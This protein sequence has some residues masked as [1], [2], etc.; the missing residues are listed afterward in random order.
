MRTRKEL[1]RTALAALKPVE[2]IDCAEFAEKNFVL[3]TTSAEPGK[4]K[5]SRTPYAEEILKAFTQA[6]IKKVVVMSSSQ[7]GKTSILLAVLARF[8]SVDPCNILLVLPTLELAQDIS[9]DRIES[10]I[11]DCAILTPLFYDENKKS[12]DKNQTMLSKFFKGGRLV[13]VGANSPTGLSSRP[14][15]LLLCDEVDRFAASAGAEGDPIAL[16]ET[17]QL[18]YWNRITGLFST[19]TLENYSRIEQ[20]YK[21]GTQ[22]EWRYECPNC[23]EWHAINYEDIT[24][25]FKYCCP[26]CG[27]EFSEKEMKNARQKYVAQN[28]NSEVRSFWVNAFSSPWVSW[29]QVMEEWKNAQ[30]NPE[31]EQTV[32][33][34]KFGR[35]YEQKGDIE[36]DSEFIKNREKYEGEVPE[37]VKI[38]TA[39]VDVQANRLE[40]EICGWN[41]EERWG[42]LRGIV[43]G[44]P[45]L[46]STW[47][48]LDKILDR[49]YRKK[50]EEMRVVRTFI[51][52]GYSAKVVY[53]YCRRK[54]NRYPIK[55]KG[56]AGIPFTPKWNKMKE[57]VLLGTIGV[58]DGKQEVF[59]RLKSKNGEKYYW[60]YPEDDEYFERGYGGKYFKQLFSEKKKIKHSGGIQYIAWEPIK[61]HIRNES[62][63]L[64]V[65]NLANI[66]SLNID[67]DKLNGTEKVVK[68]K[69][70]KSV[71]TEI[72]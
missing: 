34:T 28:E 60:H 5:I 25:D 11:R 2:K 63:D 36:N 33:N 16:A 46:L 29:E 65:Y 26:D 31:R 3:P 42:I 67:W 22:E 15:R 24:D 19:P 40:Y 20:E 62:L 44:E 18:T 54:M 37:K 55:G 52:S 8:I 1:L 56:G 6:G 10:M 7:V 61:S 57:G 23:K 17:R 53:E 27:F 38:L 9:K 68:K 58:N 14:I 35:T 59:G 4:Y 69:I 66:K 32:F 48:E 13:L 30:G 21:A 64:A 70:R 51:D 72:F 39:A 41:R 43:Y 49:N 45:S 12:R 47:E 71:A 50:N